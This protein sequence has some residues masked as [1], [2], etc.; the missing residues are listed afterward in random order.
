MVLRVR[1]GI[2]G[3]LLFLIEDRVARVWI[4]RYADR[5]DI[6]F[7]EIER[8]VDDCFMH[9]TFASILRHLKEFFRILA[10]E[11]QTPRTMR[12][13]V[14]RHIEDI[15]T[16]NFYAT[17]IA[18]MGATDSSA[19]IRNKFTILAS[20]AN[21]TCSSELADLLIEAFLNHRNTRAIHQGYEIWMEALD[22]LRGLASPYDVEKCLRLLSRVDVPGGS[23]IPLSYGKYGAGSDSRS[24]GRYNPRADKYMDRMERMVHEMEDNI[25]DL[26]RGRRISRASHWRRSA[27]MPPLLHPAIALPAPASWTN[28]FPSPAL[29]PQNNHLFDHEVD[30]LRQR[31]SN[32]EFNQQLQMALPPAAAMPAL[33]WPGN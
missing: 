4:P 12:H 27:T 25:R 24:I 14:R 33:T 17:W 2:G 13:H 19:Q 10:T 15:F 30:N 8:E 31:V 16:G 22:A 29:M 6:T 23:L 32:L 18:G 26:D 1:P 9:T 5:Y 3:G 7:A 28:P 11:N 20:L 21:V